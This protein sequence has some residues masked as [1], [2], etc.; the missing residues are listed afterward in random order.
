[1]EIVLQVPARL[2]RPKRPKRIDE[3]TIQRLTSEE[4]GSRKQSLRSRDPSLE[5]TKVAKR[6]A[7]IQGGRIR[8]AM[9]ARPETDDTDEASQDGIPDDTTRQKELLT[10]WISV[11]YLASL[12]DMMDRMSV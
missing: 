8:K 10:C 2:T 12:S 4:H 9:D 11:R 5:S 1:M 6:R 7:K 3:S